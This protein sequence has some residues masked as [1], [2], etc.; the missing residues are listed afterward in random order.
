MKLV[1]RGVNL[2]VIG[3]LSIRMGVSY[4]GK[5]LVQRLSSMVKKCL[6]ELNR[7]WRTTI[8]CR[9]AL[10]PVTHL[11]RKCLGRPKLSRTAEIR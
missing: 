4:V 11:S 1:R 10:L 2:L 8:G 9:R 5:V 3:M 7:V 6:T